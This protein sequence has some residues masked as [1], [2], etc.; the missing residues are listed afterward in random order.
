MAVFDPNTDPRPESAGMYSLFE[1]TIPRLKRENFGFRIKDVDGIARDTGVQDFVDELIGA[2]SDIAPIDL[3]TPLAVNNNSGGDAIIINGGDTD[4]GITINSNDNSS[5]HLGPS[6]LTWTTNY[7]DTITLGGITVNEG[8]TQVFNISN[9]VSNITNSVIQIDNHFHTASV[10][11]MF[12]LDGILSKEDDVQTGTMLLC[13]GDAEEPTV[14]D[15]EF[16]PGESVGGDI[17]LAWHDPC[18]ASEAWYPIATNHKFFTG[19]FLAWRTA[20]DISVTVNDECQV[21]VDGLHQHV[22]KDGLIHSVS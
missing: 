20:S 21:V 3:R 19:S 18:A 7:G 4:N 8:G 22:V 13:E 14:L 1:R 6:G 17:V 11:E 12:R 9:I 5:V 16:I 10:F 2:F 15:G